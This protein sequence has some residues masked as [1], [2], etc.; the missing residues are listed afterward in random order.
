MDYF[1]GI[2]SGLAAIIIA[3]CVPGSWSVFEGI[4]REKA[5]GRAALAGGIAESPLFA[6]VLDSRALVLRIVLCGLSPQK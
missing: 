5:T 1:K 2:L 4:S 3:E 6:P